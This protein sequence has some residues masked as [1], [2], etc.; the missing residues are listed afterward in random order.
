MQRLIT[1]LVAA[2]VF[3][4]W[5]FPAR[6]QRTTATIHGLV[7]DSSGAP[8]PRA[9][10]RLVNVDTGVSREVVTGA[11]GEFSVIFL[12]PGGYAI[13]AE[14]AGFKLRR[15]ELRVAAGEERRHVVRL[16]L[17]ELNETV[18]VAAEATALQ[19]ASPTLTDRLNRTQ[20]A[21]LPQVNRDVTQL[22]GL[23]AGS[24]P[25]RQ[26]VI[27]FNGLAAGGQTVTVDGVD[28]AGDVETPSVSMFN[29]F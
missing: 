7:E 21:E 3:A 5:A 4:S 1:V 20:V 8:I 9:T 29:A 24:K 17:G 6:A 2:L 18:T 13:E 15:E 23:Q 19:N 14:A 11:E 22:L 27:S 26:G 12:P 10:I 16:D 25:D 28:G